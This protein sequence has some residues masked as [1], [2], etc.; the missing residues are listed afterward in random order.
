MISEHCGHAISG[1]AMCKSASASRAGPCKGATASYPVLPCRR[2]ASKAESGVG[3]ESRTL[4]SSCAV[5]R[6]QEGA[7]LRMIVA[8]G[9]CPPVCVCAWVGLCVCVMSCLGGR[10]VAHCL[11][12]CWWNLPLAAPSG[13]APCLLLTAVFSM[14][15]ACKI[16]RLCS[17][18]CVPAHRG[19]RKL[20]V[21][22]LR[23]LQPFIS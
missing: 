22:S 18:I 16:V 2:T 19:T 4:R 3:L 21:C 1:L 12:S 10:K 9:C 7:F 5:L 17:S 15:A 14:A 6:W 8:I 20:V 11:K 13:F 23:M